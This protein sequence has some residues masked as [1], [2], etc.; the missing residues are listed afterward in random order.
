MF[1]RK[2]GSLELTIRNT[3]LPEEKK[4]A[5]REVFENWGLLAAPKEDEPTTDPSP[6]NPA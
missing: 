5:I 4:K 3:P 2:H 6:E 1:E